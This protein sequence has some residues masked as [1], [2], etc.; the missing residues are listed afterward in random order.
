MQDERSLEEKTV[1]KVTHQLLPFLFILY[2]IAFLDRVNG[3]RPSRDRRMSHPLRSAHACGSQ[4]PQ[5]RIIGTKIF[6]EN[7]IPGFHSLDLKKSK[8]IYRNNHFTN[9]PAALLQGADR[10]L[11]STE[12]SS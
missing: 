9:N 10:D 5:D 8:L 1:R 12:V 7:I 2:V 4:H 11:S 6:H 3:C